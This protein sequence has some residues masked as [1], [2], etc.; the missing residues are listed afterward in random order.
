MLQDQLVQIVLTA[1]DCALTES[2][3]VCNLVDLSQNTLLPI[4]LTCLLI[5]KG[6]TTLYVIAETR[7][8]WWKHATFISTIALEQQWGAILLTFQKYELR[9]FI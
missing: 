8:L 9:G 3:P 1:Q 2:P 4:T 7:Q 5:C 6:V